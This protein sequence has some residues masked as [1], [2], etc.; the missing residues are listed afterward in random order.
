MSAKKQKTKPSSLRPLSFSSTP[1]PEK[2]NLKPEKENGNLQ[3]W[4]ERLRVLH[5]LPL[6]IHL[7][8]QIQIHSLPS[9]IH[10]QIQLQIH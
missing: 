10:L 6:Q 1:P 5:S 7:Q 9:Q 2:E 3:Q 8:K 4:T